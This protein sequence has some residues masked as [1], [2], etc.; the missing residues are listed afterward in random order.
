M[1]GRVQSWLVYLAAIAGLAACGGGSSDPMEPFNTQSLAWQ[2][3]DPSI[4]GQE[5]SVFEQLGERAQCAN[6]RVPLDYE[7]PSKGEAVVALLR[8]SAEDPKQRAGA[9]YFN[10]GGPGGDGLWMAAQFGALWS[11]ADPGN[12]LGKPLKQLSTRYDLIG[13][14]P[15][16]V[17]ASTRLYCASNEMLVEVKLP[18]ADRSQGNIQNMLYNARL[19]A[20]ACRKNPLSKYINTEQT[21]RDLDLARSLMGDSQFHY[22]GYSYGTWLGAWYASRFPERVGRMLLDSSMNFSGTFDDAKLMQPMGYQRILDQVLAPYAARHDDKFSLGTNADDVRAIYGALPNSVKE[23]VGF[24][25]PLNKSGDAVDGVLLLSGAKG[26]GNLIDTFPLGSPDDLH[27]LIEARVFSND[28]AYNLRARWRAHS[29]VN[30]HFKSPFQRVSV[31]LEPSEAVFDAVSCNDTPSN[32]DSQF[33]IDQGNAHAV[34]YPLRGG[35]VTE[36]PC[37]YWGGP[38][39]TKPPLSSTAQAGPILMVQ[40]QYDGATP[41]EGA[42]TAFAAMPNAGM[43]LINDEYSHGAFPYGT[44]CVDQAVADY[45]ASGIFPGRGQTLV[46]QGKPLPGDPTPAALKKAATPGEGGQPYVDPARAADLIESIH[47]TLKSNNAP[48]RF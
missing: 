3:C 41:T 27:Q 32:R 35:A 4:L 22:I 2:A 10:P 23:Y 46:C 15:R 34:K 14:S 20:E 38:V 29:A 48:R 40:T 6:M 7:N 45:F 42:M 8:V 36:Q 18:S 19:K 13:F 30:Y 47:R 16:G 11:I 17:G 28:A 21:V 25:M 26:A 43:I 1:L 31:M 24:T 44:T 12:S 9:I 37:L 33:W 5:T 39:V